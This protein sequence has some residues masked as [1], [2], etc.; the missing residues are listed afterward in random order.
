M[1]IALSKSFAV[2]VFLTVVEQATAGMSGG[3]VF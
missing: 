2:H 3:C 1:K